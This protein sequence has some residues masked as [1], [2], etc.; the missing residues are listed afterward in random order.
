MQ[1]PGWVELELI[2]D[3][4]C[5]GPRL[6]P[7]V[8]GKAANLGELI[9]VGFPVPP[10]FCVTTVAYQQ[11][12]ADAELGAVIDAVGPGAPPRP[13]TWRPRQDSNLRPSD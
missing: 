10:G 2:L 7:V 4:A 3:L 13:L 12:A 9:R 5:L 1:R 8:G 6:L 11:I